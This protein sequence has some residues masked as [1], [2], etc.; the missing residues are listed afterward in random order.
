M[1]ALA[2][3]VGHALTDATRP[4]EFKHIAARTTPNR[5]RL[6]PDPIWI[7]SWYEHAEREARA[8][9]AGKHLAYGI[10]YIEF[11]K[12]YEFVAT[13]NTH[14]L[15][16]DQCLDV[17]WSTIGIVGEAAVARAQSL[18]IGHIESW[19]SQ[20]RTPFAMI[21]VLEVG[22]RFG[23][24]SHFIISNVPG[25]QL[26]FRKGCFN[27]LWDIARHRPVYSDAIKTFRLALEERGHLVQ[28]GRFRYMM[29]GLSPWATLLHDES[30]GGLIPLY[31]FAAINIKYEGEIG[32]PRLTTW[33]SAFAMSV[34]EVLSLY[35]DH[36]FSVDGYQLYGDQFLQ[37]RYLAVS[38]NPS[39]WD[40]ARRNAAAYII[41]A[42]AT[43]ICGS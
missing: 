3:S 29:K 4:S 13:A 24:H 11:V 40:L 41:Q 14:G 2:S 38:E 17:T 20:H 35:L 23:L 22:A 10:T 39:Y 26:E 30:V 18:L 15:I 43:M 8:V 31:R 12:A 42:P 25:S 1:A 36:S 27:W 32:I 9:A 37:D 21:A 33:R 34:T 5:I 7:A 19:F 6:T 28:W 16:L